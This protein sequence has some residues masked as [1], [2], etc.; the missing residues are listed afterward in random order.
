MTMW[1]GTA[2]LVAMLLGACA[3][4]SKG[5]IDKVQAQLRCAM[6]SAE[7]EA[8]VG[9]RLYKLEPR[10][11]RFTHLYRNGM[12][13]LSFVFEDDRLR[14][15]QVVVVQGFLGTKEEPVVN[16]CK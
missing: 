6:S 15:S 16:H 4:V 3:I 7:V 11:P 13:D 5:Q 1:S 14:S 9:R 8:L 12:T 10:D 2:V